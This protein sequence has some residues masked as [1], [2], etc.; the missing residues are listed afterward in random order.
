MQDF[1]AN[2]LIGL[3]TGLVSGLVTGLYSG[4]IVS[5]KNRF[6][7]L[8]S[9]LLVHINS[10]GYMDDAGRVRTELGTSSRILRVGELLLQF[11][12][13]SAGRTAFAGHKLVTIALTQAQAGQIDA[14]ALEQ[15]LRPVVDS[16]VRIRPTARVYL[17]WGRV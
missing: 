9:E 14:R 13:K 11:G 16:F 1:G 2:L 5:R 6:D 15:Q 4:Q 8:R 17:P 7:S 10:I 12:H 3:G